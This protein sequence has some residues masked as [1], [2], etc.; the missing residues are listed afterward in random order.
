MRYAF[1][2]SGILAALA[3]GFTLFRA[4]GGPMIN[5]TSMWLLL[6]SLVVAVFGCLIAKVIHWC[7]PCPD[8]CISNFPTVKLIRRG[9]TV[10]SMFSGRTI[11]VFLFRNP[12]YVEALLAENDPDNV[13]CNKRALARAKARYL[14]RVVGSGNAAAGSPDSGAIGAAKLQ[15]A[16]EGYSPPAD[17]Y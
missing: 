5:P 15:E 17:G 12:L 14:R 11:A 6:A 7:A 3:L 8:S 16:G 9:M 13:K 2:P 1:V 10:F 4:P